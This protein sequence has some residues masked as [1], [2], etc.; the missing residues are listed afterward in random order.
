MSVCLSRRN[1]PLWTGQCS[2]AFTKIS[3]DDGATM[4][5]PGSHKSN[6][7]YTQFA[8]NEIAQHSILVDGV[9]GAIEIFMDP[10]NALAFADAIMHGSA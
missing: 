7:M 8:E 5:L 9:V 6:I 3:P 2:V 4:V 1:I 10:G